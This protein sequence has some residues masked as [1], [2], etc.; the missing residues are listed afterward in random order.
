MGSVYG[1]N[2]V[3]HGRADT[4][5]KVKPLHKYFRWRQTVLANILFAHGDAVAGIESPFWR[6]ATVLSFWC[7][8]TIAVSLV[9]A[10]AASF[11]VLHFANR[12][13]A[14]PSFYDCTRRLFRLSWPKIVVCS[15]L[16]SL[17][18]FTVAWFIPT[19]V[20]DAKALL[21]IN[22]ATATLLV[23]CIEIDKKRV[24]QSQT[25]EGL[26]VLKLST[27]PYWRRVVGALERNPALTMRTCKALLVR[28]SIMRKQR[29]VQNCWT[30]PTPSQRTFS[31]Q[32]QVDFEVS[33]LVFFHAA[34]T[35]AGMYAE[36]IAIACATSVL[37]VYRSHPNY[38]W[39]GEAG[40]VTP[41]KTVLARQ[42]GAALIVDLVCCIVEISCGLPLR[43]SQGLSA[44]VIGMFV[45]LSI[46]SIV[47][48]AL[49]Y[50]AHT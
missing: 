44:F 48:C 34:E 6:F 5:T 25:V 16:T 21:Y 49:A 26:A 12:P 36:Y 8:S 33:R 42:V 28:R 10:Q 31:A 13:N 18:A 50:I 38:V 23:V 30:E 37:Y 2:F 24:F 15:A 46:V 20:I 35:L 40:E 29:K 17:A 47:L 7:S 14:T 3:R 43:I 27:K 22:F 11:R 39:A 9:F 4:R 19:A 41:T 45:Y 1:G 32:L